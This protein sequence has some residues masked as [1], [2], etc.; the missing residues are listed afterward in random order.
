MVVRVSITRPYLS[1]RWLNCADHPGHT[2]PMCS[3]E[4]NTDPVLREVGAAPPRSALK[5]VARILDTFGPLDEMLGVNEIARRSGLPK[6][7]ASRFVRE[8]IDVGFLERVEDQLGLGLRLFELGERASRRRSVRDVALPFMA[9][10]RAATGQT[11]H[12]ALMDELDVVYVEILRARN[13]PPL[14]SRVGGRLPPHA[15]GVGKAMLAHL[16]TSVVDMVIEAGLPRLGPRTITNPETLRRGLRRIRC[17]GVAFEQEESGA[18]IVCVAAAVNGPGG[19]VIAAISASGWAGG[20]NLRHVA[21]AVRT[22][23]LGISRDLLRAAR[24]RS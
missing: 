9:D 20:I 19:R 11:I 21:P 24:R 2:Q 1:T 13:A 5:R 22:A 18:G 16:P 3:T 23:A 15:T 8:M 14:P 12:L 4:S 6:A 17:D 10:L 7:T